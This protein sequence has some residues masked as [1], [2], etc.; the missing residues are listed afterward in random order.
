MLSHEMALDLGFREKAPY[1][2]IVGA[3]ALALWF[4][5]TSDCGERRGVAA[6][7]G[8]PGWVESIDE[9]S[10]AAASASAAAAAEA[11]AER[12]RWPIDAGTLVPLPG[13]PWPFKV[14]SVQLLCLDL[15][16]SMALVHAGRR[17]LWRDMPRHSDHQERYQLLNSDEISKTPARARSEVERAAVRA[18][19][20]RAAK[21][22][23]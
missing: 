14:A 12:A 1:L 18:F 5:F 7:L 2:A 6:D 4:L 16:G 20:A 8:R 19:T 15:V 11:T 21:L 10:A 9:R 3:T 17:Y 23:P 22:C 13:E